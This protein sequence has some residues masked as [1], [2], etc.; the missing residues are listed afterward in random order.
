MIASIVS[1]ASYGISFHQYFDPKKHLERDKVWDDHVDEWRAYNQMKWYLNRVCIA[2]SDLEIVYS[3]CSPT[4]II[5]K[6][7]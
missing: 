3:S 7:E 4:L 1:R 2:L 6:Y 5:R